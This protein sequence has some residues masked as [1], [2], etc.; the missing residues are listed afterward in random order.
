[1]VLPA[2]SIICMPCHAA[3]LSADDTVTVLAL[4][5]FGGGMI[6]IGSVWFSGRGRPAGD[7]P[8]L[9]Q[10]I[11]AAARSLFSRRIWN[12]I[13]ALFLD[14]LLQRRLFRISKE[15]W[16]LH[17]L[18]FYPFLFRFIWGVWALTASLAWPQWPSTWAMLNK[19]NP[20]TAFLFDLSGLMVIIGV[21]GMIFR[22]LQMR[23]GK[24]LMNSTG[25][26]SWWTKWLGS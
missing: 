21:G 12:I 15:R 1:M 13:G 9:M 4:L 10:A 20:L 14:G 6:F 22:R 23:S 17:A 2:K 5:F 24:A 11:R 16:L 26:N 18:I 19:N 3:T 7:G 25:S 8:K